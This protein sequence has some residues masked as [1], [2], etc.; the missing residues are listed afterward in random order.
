MAVFKGADIAEDIF[1]NAAGVK[2]VLSN[3][4]TGMGIRTH[5]DD[6]SAQFPETVEN[7]SSGEKTAAAVYT[8]C[9]HFQ[10]L[11]L[12]GKYPQ[13][14]IDDL[15]VLCVRKGTGAGMTFG[16]ADIGQVCQ[17]IKIIMK[18]YTVQCCF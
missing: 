2:R 4:V 12:G 15:T 17:N 10:A 1:Q 14:L 11:T 16:F 8:A 3:P 18:L 7:V 5:G 13:N 9:I 6:F